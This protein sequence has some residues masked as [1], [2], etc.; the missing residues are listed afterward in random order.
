MIILED[1]HC[2]HYRAHYRL[3]V[4]KDGDLRIE[5]F[6]DYR[7]WVP[8]YWHDYDPIKLKYP[9]PLDCLILGE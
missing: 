1:W 8:T 2:T 6:N 7:K 9:N 4:N 3:I 5:R